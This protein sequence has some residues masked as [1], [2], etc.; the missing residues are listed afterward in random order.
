M[1]GTILRDA[2]R[3]I[4]LYPDADGFKAWEKVRKDASRL[5]CNVRTSSLIE[6]LA[7]IKERE[8]QVDL[9]DYLI[10]EQKKRND[11]DRRQDFADLIEERLAILTID[12]GLTESEAESEIIT[13]GFYSYT[14]DR[15]LCA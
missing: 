9:A 6:E 2:Y 4:I 11:P 8:D 3:R 12:G 7:S 14:L 13:S 5:G 10:D 1:S 15:V